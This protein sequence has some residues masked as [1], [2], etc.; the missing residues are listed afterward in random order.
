[1]IDC[2]M[3]ILAL[4]KYNPKNP[5]IRNEKNKKQQ[6]QQQQRSSYNWGHDR[7]THTLIE[8][9]NECFI[10]SVLKIAT[11]NMNVLGKKGKES[12]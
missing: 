11:L 4:Q 12:K 2:A 3:C 5:K 7:Y 6:Q 9:M 10:A 1:M 8:W